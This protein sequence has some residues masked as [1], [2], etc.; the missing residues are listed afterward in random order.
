[1]K[2]TNRRRQLAALKKTMQKPLVKAFVRKALAQA[3]QQKDLEHESRRKQ[4]KTTIDANAV[5][6]RKLAFEVSRPWRMQKQVDDMEAKVKIAER[7]RTRAE[8]QKEKAEAKTRQQNA[9]L[10]ELSDLRRHMAWM[11]AKL[12]PER[13]ERLIARAPRRLG[14]TDQ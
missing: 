5:L 6:K 10:G 2:A 7:M 11:R 12:G 9:Q 1:M 13:V 8:A 4:L 14:Y 3:R